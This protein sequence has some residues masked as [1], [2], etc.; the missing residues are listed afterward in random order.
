[1]AT[2]R[3]TRRRV[4]FTIIEL[5]V[6]ISI[7]ALLISILLPALGSARERARFVKW[8]A[9]SNSMRIDQRLVTQYNME[10]Q[11]TGSTTLWNRAVGDPNYAARVDFEPKDLD[12][13]LHRGIQP[14]TANLV[15]DLWTENA[16]DQ[17][18]KGKGGLYFSGAQEYATTASHH[19]ILD[20][21]SKRM[22]VGLWV[23]V[24]NWAPSWEP[25]FAQNGEERGWQVR[26]SGS[27]TRFNW[28]T[29]VT[30]A[31]TAPTDD[32]KQVY[33]SGSVCCGGDFEAPTN[34]SLDTN[35]YFIVGTYNGDLTTDAGAIDQDKK[36]YVN[37]K[38]DNA[39]DT[40]GGRHI[41]NSPQRITLAARDQ[42]TIS[43]SF[44]TGWI[45]EA[46][47]MND[48]MTEDE[49]LLMY[50]VGATRRRN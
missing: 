48:E 8:A 15:G 4:G 3:S 32:P 10:Q 41:T 38:R 30:T 35:W 44:F 17:R 24:D 39:T 43:G 1:M 49:V 18:W 46:F 42:G 25:W 5:L 31:G 26:R 11:G 47:I 36:A 37:G 45:D 33:T 34:M 14:T 50:N 27:N 28:T 12:M 16:L 6:V 9:F 13:E 29:R 22:S 23:R 7:I 20:T 40:H 21:F 2:G 19:P